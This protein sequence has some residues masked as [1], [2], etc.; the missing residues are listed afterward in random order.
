MKRRTA[1]QLLVSSALLPKGLSAR[2][3][4]VEFDSLRAPVADFEIV[5]PDILCDLS[6][7]LAGLKLERHFGNRGGRLVRDGTGSDAYLLL[8][9]PPQHLYEEAFYETT[10]AE[11][12]PVTVG[13][14]RG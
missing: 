13:Q 6:V 10:F 3:A 8:T 2:A 5:D 12:P 7:H 1:L 11:P 9:L 14:V 4:S